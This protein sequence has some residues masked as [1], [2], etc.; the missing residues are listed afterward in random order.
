M[1]IAAQRDT[2]Y[3]TSGSGHQGTRGSGSRGPC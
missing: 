2:Y 3:G 1:P